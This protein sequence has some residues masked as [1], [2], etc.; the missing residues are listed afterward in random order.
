[1][2]VVHIAVRGGRKRCIRGA[3]VENAGVVLSGNETSF[4]STFFGQAPDVTCQAARPAWT[5]TS[6]RRMGS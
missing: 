5:S 1:M 4:H 3:F 6:G 2:G